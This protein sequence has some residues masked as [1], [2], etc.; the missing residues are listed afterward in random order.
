VL[1][2]REFSSSHRQPFDLYRQ[3]LEHFLFR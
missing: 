1:L 3:E 2:G